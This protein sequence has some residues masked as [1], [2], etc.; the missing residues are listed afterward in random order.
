MQGKQKTLLDV[1]ITCFLSLTIPA[2]LG[3]GLFVIGSYL[4][5]GMYFFISFGISFN[6]SFEY[7]ASLTAASVL[8]TKLALMTAAEPCI[9][10][11][12]FVLVGA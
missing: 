7:N 5:S 9:H 4:F 3:M 6:I 12:V 2:C 10:R 11:F 1:L 8:L